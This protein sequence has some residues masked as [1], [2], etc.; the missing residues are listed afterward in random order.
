MSTGRSPS[1]V[2][3]FGLPVPKTPEQAI[4]AFS[5]LSAEL[6]TEKQI[7]DFLERRFEPPTAHAVFSAIVSDSDLLQLAS[8]PFILQAI[9]EIGR[10]LLRLRKVSSRAVIE[11]YMYRFAET[12]PGRNDESN[13]ARA[14]DIRVAAGKLAGSL[15][16]GR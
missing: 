15:R 6:F 11:R 12:S 2:S 8:G 16:A 13:G 14:S 9:T 1:R 4:A 10:D 7:Q 5:E 3:N